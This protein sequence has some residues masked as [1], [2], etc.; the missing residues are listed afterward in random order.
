[1]RYISTRSGMTPSNFSDVLLEG[2][3]PD[4]GLVVPETIPAV[5]AETIESWRD[6]S[7]A[8]LATEV[9]TLSWIDIRREDLTQ[10]F[11]AAYVDQ[12]KVVMILPFTP[13]DEI[14]ALVDLSQGPTLAFKDMAIQF[15][16]EALPYVLQQRGQTLNIL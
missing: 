14:T 4:G 8:E 12:F 1:M 3:A 6:L 15:L 13:I 9:I 2:L 16:V 11:Q 7:Y 10:L 5:N